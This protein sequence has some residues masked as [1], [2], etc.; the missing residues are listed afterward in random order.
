M[1][2][3]RLRSHSYRLPCYLLGLAFRLSMAERVA[4]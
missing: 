3:K 4:M 1:R 2:R